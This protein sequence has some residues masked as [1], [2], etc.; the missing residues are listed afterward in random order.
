MEVYRY[1]DISATCGYLVCV[2]RTCGIYFVDY[3]LHALV[4][5]TDGDSLCVQWCEIMY[6][7][8]AFSFRKFM[9][10]VHILS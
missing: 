1:T 3:V 2:W 10:L 7:V 6:Y 8:I 5:F 4:H 9:S